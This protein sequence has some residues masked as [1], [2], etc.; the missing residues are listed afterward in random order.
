[1][2]LALDVDGDV[3]GKVSETANQEARLP[4][5]PRSKLDQHT[6]VAG[7]LRD[8]DAMNFEQSGFDPRRVICLGLDGL[9]KQ[10]AARRSVEEAA[11]DAPGR[12]RKA[13]EHGRGEIH[14]TVLLL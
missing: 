9:L 5:R 13:C 7:N 12:P 8:F 4:A 3:S 10:L 2:G 6:A 14:L 11:G 1:T